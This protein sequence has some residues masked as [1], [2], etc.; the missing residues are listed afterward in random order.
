M[1]GPVP[2]SEALNWTRRLLES[3]E[4]AAFALPADPTTVW[5]PPSDATLQRLDFLSRLYCQL[6]QV[7]DAESRVGTPLDPRSVGSTSM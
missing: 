2:G 3:A 7:V 1:Q 5:V 6:R 4:K